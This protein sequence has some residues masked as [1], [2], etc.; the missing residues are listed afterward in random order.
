MR[1]FSGKGKIIGSPE[2]Y[3]KLHDKLTDLNYERNKLLPASELSQFPA[4]NRLLYNPELSTGIPLKDFSKAQA[5]NVL[6]VFTGL[7]SKTRDW[8][9]IPELMD[10]ALSGKIDGPA[11]LGTLYKEL[12][13]KPERLITRERVRYSW[14]TDG[15]RGFNKLMAMPGSVTN[16]ILDKTFGKLVSWISREPTYLLEY[17]MAMEKLRPIIDS[18]IY[19]QDQAEIEAMN[20]ALRNMTKYIHNPMDRA[21]FERNARIYSPFWFA[22][23][24]AVRRA[25]RMFEENPQAFMKY[26]KINLAVN[27]YYATHNNNGQVYF[28]IPGSEWLDGFI[29]NLFGGNSSK[30]NPG[31]GLSMDMSTLTSV[32]PFT[33]NSFK[34]VAENLLSPQFGQL[35]S[36]P[37]KALNSVGGIGSEFY[38]KFAN[39]LLGNITS[40]TGFMSDIVPSSVYRD[41]GNLAR[42]EWNKLSGDNQD[43]GTIVGVQ[44]KAMHSIMD[45]LRTSIVERLMKENEG[46]LKGD[47]LAVW[48]NANADGYIS[49]YYDKDTKS[50][51]QHRQ[52]LMDQSQTAATLLYGLKT[53]LSFSMPFPVSITALFP[54]TQ[55][56]NAIMAQKMPDGSPIPLSAAYEEFAIKYPGKMIDLVSTS[57][58]PYGAFPENQAYLNWAKKAPSLLDSNGIPYL[59][60]ALIPQGGTYQPAAFQSQLS[61][62][63]RSEDTPQQFLD[64]TLTQMG[65]DFYY[66]Y[67]VPTYYSN[68]EYG[69]HWTGDINTSTISYD[70]YKALQT[71]A[72]GF[73]NQY[74]PTWLSNGSPFGN[75]STPRKLSVLDD[76]KQLVSSP[77]MQ[78]QIVKNQLLTSGDVDALVAA[79]KYYESIL[80][81]ALSMTASERYNSYFANVFRQNA[82]NPVNAGTA[83]IFTILSEF[84]TAKSLNQS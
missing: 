9:F 37:M 35:V 69:G 72:Q 26:L 78:E 4:A 54:K 46:K 31:F 19:S 68:P 18:G 30:A 10:Q 77:E 14:Q 79:Y 50:G 1:D 63:L 53:I 27:K 49:E 61:L 8:E 76:L 15:V 34:D 74:N 16:A 25:W 20:E 58:A 29:L 73:G 36:I 6:S 3:Q 43:T 62:K 5:Y 23:N 55:E 44:I 66:N 52:E 47:A 51:V 13:A 71:E 24:Q 39:F 22:K 57:Q 59:A 81:Q 7:N 12:N 40:K 38:N 45:N 83:N 2:D 65:D 60:A 80:P 41:F 56:L 84:P 33:G 42:F 75:T 17:H 11:E 67:L 70:G 32:L 82:A 21:A 48:A 64:A 28:S